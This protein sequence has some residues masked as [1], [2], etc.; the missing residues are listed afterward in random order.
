MN[1]QI[2]I[3]D[4][5]HF[6]NEQLICVAGIDI[7]T[8]E[9]LRPTS[10]NY[11]SAQDLKAYQIKPGS[12][13]SGNFQFLNPSFLPHIED[14]SYKNLKF[15]RLC[16]KNEFREALKSSLSKNIEDGFGIDLGNERKCIS[17]SLNPSKSLITISVNPKSVFVFQDDGFGKKRIKIHFTDENGKEFKYI[18]VNDLGYYAKD[19]NYEKVNSIVEKQ[20]N[21]FL[22]VGIGR[23]YK[24]Q[25]GRDGYW[26]QVNGIYSFPNYFEAARIY[27]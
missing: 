1:R 24:S 18:P 17:S 8:G 10:P 14:V 12:V 9:C 22:R 15:E 13:L 4:V 6:K 27:N 26:I 7:N 21:V 2:V 25:D 16:S 23:Q 5:T 11:F 19:Y 20:D 3:T